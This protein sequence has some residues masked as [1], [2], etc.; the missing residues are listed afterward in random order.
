[1]SSTASER[2]RILIA[3]DSATTRITLVGL[4]EKW[5]YDVVAVPDGAA[6]WD[7]FQAD[8]F[9]LV[10]TDWEMPDVDG[11]E[12]I[13]RIRAR[14]DTGFIYTILLTARDQTEDVV[15]AMDDGADAY[16]IKPLAPEELRARIHAGVRIVRLEQ[17]LEKRRQELLE[18]QTR[19]LDS[20]RQAAV[21]RLAAGMAHEI[22][23][24]IAVISGNIDIFRDGVLALLDVL[25]QWEDGR[26][27][28]QSADPG[29]LQ[30]ID[31]LCEK[32]DLPWLRSQLPVYLD[33][34]RDNIVRVQDIVIRLQDFSWHDK[35][36]IAQIDPIQAIET[37]IA[38][39]APEISRANVSLQ[40][41]F[42]PVPAITCHPAEFNQA[43]YNILHNAIQASGT[44]DVV[45][46][47][48]STSSENV[49]IRIADRG[50]GIPDDLLRQIFEPFFTTRSV[51]SGTGLGLHYSR[52]IF[53]QAGG[54]VRCSPRP[55]GGT[56]FDITLPAAESTD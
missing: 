45:D 5:G 34:M 2:I 47:S 54:S 18:T 9:R 21:G 3:E 26:D 52:R 15:S 17:R 16:L 38:V 24:P 36:Q 46:V 31:E 12:L 10:L 53:Q 7:E 8:V 48:T 13:R 1:M 33:S 4:L 49:V 28:V 14:P 23:N 11:L 44:D 55:R 56:V 6:A 35:A 37:S 42:E 29:A 43:I 25:N 50:P 39:L 32:Y 51:G 20:D 22:N 19:L 40:T 30:Q 41:S 27:T